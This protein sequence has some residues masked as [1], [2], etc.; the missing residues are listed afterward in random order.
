MKYSILGFGLMISLATP[1]FAQ[2]DVSDSR[3]LASEGQSAHPEALVAIEQATET[4]YETNNSLQ[5]ALDSMDEPRDS[6]R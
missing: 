3:Q 4:L 6:A 1:A 2:V 5:S